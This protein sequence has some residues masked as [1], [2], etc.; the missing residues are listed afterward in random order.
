[1]KTDERENENQYK[2]QMEIEKQT[3]LKKSRS[4][5]VKEYGGLDKL[6]FVDLS[7]PIPQE[8]EVLVKIKAAS[9]NPVD[10]N[11]L[12]GG[13]ES[14]LHAQFPY[15]IGWDMSG[16]IEERGHSARRFEIG[17]KVFGFCRRPFL[18]S[19]TYAEY[20]SIPESYLCKAPE[21][22]SLKDVAAV[23]LA[24]LTAYQGLITI[25]KLQPKETIMILGASGGVGSFA[26]QI[27]KNIGAKVISVAGTNHQ[28]FI[29]KLGSDI[30]IDYNDSEWVKKA[31][32]NAPDFIFDCAGGDTRDKGVYAIKKGG[33]VISLTSNQFPDKSINFMSMFVEP[34]SH[35]LQD[36]A[37]W[38]D[39]GKL[40][41]YVSKYF[42]LDNAIE[43]LK[44]NQQGRTEGKIIISV[45]E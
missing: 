38:I 28:D 13:M 6:Q 32:N 27:A 2:S 18:K 45:H 30:C 23:P 29:K 35:Q 25:G 1:M 33:R 19:G 42:T 39:Q 41:V 26:V 44:L 40:R 31:T 22:I 12:S 20:I 4:L 11:L 8:G 36:L 15:V 10:R 3:T 17:D 7:R 43:A 37:N 21:K 5:V 14:T 34:N 9:V 24:G 16:T